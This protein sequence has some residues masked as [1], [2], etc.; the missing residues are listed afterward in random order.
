MLF[1]G[2]GESFTERVKA[3][4]QLLGVYFSSETDKKYFF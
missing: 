2:V 3:T 4:K 1:F